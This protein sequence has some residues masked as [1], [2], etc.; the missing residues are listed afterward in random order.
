MADRHKTYRMKN[1]KTT[2]GFQDDN[3]DSN[4]V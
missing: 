4:N 2:H 3:E 1:R